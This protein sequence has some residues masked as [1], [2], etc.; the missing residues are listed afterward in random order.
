MKNGVIVCRPI[1]IGVDEKSNNERFRCTGQE[2]HSPLLYV[3]SF[4]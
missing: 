2:H 3:T 4:T 1:N